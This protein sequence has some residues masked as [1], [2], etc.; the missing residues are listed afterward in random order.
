MKQYIGVMLLV[1]GLSLSCNASEDEHTRPVPSRSTSYTKAAGYST[2][3]LASLWCIVKNKRGK[4][5]ELISLAN[6]AYFMYHVGSSALEELR[7]TPV[8]SINEEK[9][10]SKL[11]FLGLAI[12]GSF[13]TLACMAMGSAA[14]RTNKTP[15]NR[16]FNAHSALAFGWNAKRIFEKAQK[17]YRKFFPKVEEN[18]AA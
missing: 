13:T 1:V 16:L 9:A 3:A 2:L 15:S 11:K 17:E 14:I 10:P 18:E 8:S 4:L 6:H 7:S 12:A 5:G